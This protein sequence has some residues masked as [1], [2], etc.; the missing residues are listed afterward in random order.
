MRL[1]FLVEWWAGLRVFEALA[2]KSRYTDWPT[3]RVWQGNGRIVPVHAEQHSALISALQFGNIG[4]ADRLTRASR[5]T[6]DRW[7][8]AAAERAEELSPFRR[9]VTYRTTRSGTHTPSTY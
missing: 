8:K 9:D 3:L 2:L 4:M 1:L 5:S 7:I 6:A